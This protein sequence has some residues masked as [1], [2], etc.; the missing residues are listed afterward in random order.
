LRDVG[1]IEDS[2]DIITGYAEVNGR[3]TVYIPISNHAEAT[4]LS[5]V[6][7]VKASLP[8]FQSVVPEDIGLDYE[9][10]QSSYVRSSLLS[11]VKEGLL[12]A[13]LTGVMVLL[14]LRE[15]R[16]ALIVVTTIPFALL[17][18]IVALWAAGQTIN[19]ITLNGLALA[20]GIL[21]EESTVMMENIHS[22]LGQ[23]RGRAVAVLEASKEVQI[24]RLLA[25]LCVLAVFVPSFF[26]TGVSRSL[27]VPLSLAVGFAMAASYLL[28]SSL[29]PVLSTWMLREHAHHAEEGASGLSRLRVRLGSVFVRLIARRWF[30]VS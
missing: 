29:V 28:S 7:A 20:V 26:M 27:F 5:I 14:F 8:Q 25:M 13:I 3:R 4:T 30:F 11:V 18:A 1:T 2:S 16:S 22:H 15:W 9:F 23:G 21:V 6:D 24:P 17:T 12:G 19:I 10:D